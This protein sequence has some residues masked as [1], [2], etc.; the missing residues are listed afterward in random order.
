MMCLIRDSASD[1]CTR[2]PEFSRPDSYLRSR[3]AR[4]P[5]VAFDE[6]DFNCPRKAGPAAFPG[7]WE[8]SSAR[9]P[10]FR[11]ARFSTASEISGGHNCAIAR[12][13]SDA[14]NKR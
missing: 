6:T 14:L 11:P 13:R 1:V 7:Y 5:L 2:T 10:I 3:D 8:V 12:D 4:E 9:G